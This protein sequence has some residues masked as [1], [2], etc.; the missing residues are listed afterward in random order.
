MTQYGTHLCR[1]EAAAWIIRG[2]FP[3]RGK[4]S[5]G[6]LAI[7]LRSHLSIEHQ[8]SVKAPTW[9]DRQLVSEGASLS[10]AGFGA[11]VREALQART[12]FLVGE[13]LA[14]RLGLR[15]VFAR[16]LLMTLRDR[17]LAEAGGALQRESGLV[18]HR[19][20]EDVRVSGVY[21]QSI[22]LASGR[23]A[24]LADGQGFS[25]VPWRPAIERRLGQHV[26]AIVRGSSVSWQLAK[27][28]DNSI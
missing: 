28:R 7:E 24:I 6:G 9:L 21:R 17:E 16:N 19:L 18:H 10:R 12:N 5:V 13:G 26:T 27:Q 15:V 8:V 4:R 3:A 22:Q 11:Q 1:F 20:S 14:E 23:F 25:L 2:R